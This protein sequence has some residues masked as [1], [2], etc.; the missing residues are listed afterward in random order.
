MV[1]VEHLEVLLLVFV[2]VELELVL[3]L[4]E[5]LL[6]VQLAEVLGLPYM[7]HYKKMP[8]TFYCCNSSRIYKAAL[9]SIKNQHPIIHR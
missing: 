1:S 4:L 9:N 5:V 8:A 3:G 6:E 7:K 2:L